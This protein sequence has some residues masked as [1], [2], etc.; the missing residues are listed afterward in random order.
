ME[1]IG[2]ALM[3]TSLGFPSLAFNVGFMTGGDRPARFW[4]LIAVATGPIMTVWVMYRYLVQLV[5]SAGKHIG[6]TR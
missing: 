3:F 1:Q 6:A 2:L 4:Q 5:F